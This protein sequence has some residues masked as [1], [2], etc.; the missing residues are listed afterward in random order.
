MTQE[1]DNPAAENKEPNCN[2]EDVLVN[3]QKTFSRVSNRTAQVVGEDAAAIIIG[4]VAFSINLRVSPNGDYLLVSDQ[5]T[6]ELSL[7]GK[8]EP[9]VRFYHKKPALQSD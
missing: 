4:P 5:G 8:V 6:I 1:S 7:E 3:L 2:L 9:D